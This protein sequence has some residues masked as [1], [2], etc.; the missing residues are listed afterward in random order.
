[1]ETHDLKVLPLL[2]N[3]FYDLTERTYKFYNTYDVSV[4]EVEPDKEMRMD[5]I[6]YMLYKTTDYVDFLLKYNN[7]SNPL[8]I[9][10]GDKIYYVVTEDTIDFFRAFPKDNQN[11]APKLVNPNKSTRRD[12]NRQK[13]V[14][15][16]YSL[17]PTL[18]DTPISPV[19]IDGNKIVVGRGLF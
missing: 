2:D 18:N 15:K 14:D 17:P 9:K 13:Y 4:Y 12:Q 10:S 16:G 7:I 11:V 19:E 5:L 1:M 8:N 6:S 3:N